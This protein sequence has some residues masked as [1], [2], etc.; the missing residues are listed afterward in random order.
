M[1]NSLPTQRCKA[2]SHSAGQEISLCVSYRVQKISTFDCILSHM[3]ANP[4]SHPILLK[5]GV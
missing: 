4:P 1:I 3:G 5:Y 2:D